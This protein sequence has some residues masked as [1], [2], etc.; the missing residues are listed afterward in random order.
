MLNY[1]IAVKGAIHQG[2]GVFSSLPKRQD[3]DVED[4]ESQPQGFAKLPKTIIYLV[5]F[6]Y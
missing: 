5:T 2:Q 6:Y 4:I 3:S 1:G